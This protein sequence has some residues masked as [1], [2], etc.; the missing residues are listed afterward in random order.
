[1]FT[2][3]LENSLV[4]LAL[5]AVVAPVCY[6]LRSRPAA[7]HLLWLV[8]LVRLVL[9]P[10]PIEPPQALQGFVDRATVGITDLVS[11][12]SA[13]PAHDVLGEGE[14]VPDLIKPTGAGAALDG[15]VARATPTSATSPAPAE[16]AL[17]LAWLDELALVIWIGG[18]LFMLL[19]QLRRCQRLETLVSHAEEAP[20]ELL[21]TVGYMAR[22][23]GVKPPEVRLVKG[24]GSPIIWSLKRP[25]F[26]WPTCRD[27]A[28]SSTCD[29]GIVAH[30]LAHLRRRDHW[31]AWFEMVALCVC[32]WNPVFWAVRR[33][34]RLNAEQACDAWA[35]WA[36]PEHRRA[37]AEALIDIAEQRLKPITRAPVLG[38][39][40]SEPKDFQKRLS[41]IM[42][43]RVSHQASQLIA[44]AAALTAIIL[45]PGITN[46]TPP[47]GGPSGLPGI[48]PELVERVNSVQR[49]TAAAAHY[50]AGRW[51]DAATVYGEIVAARPEDGWARH[52]LGHAL[53]EVGRL[54]EAFA[55]FQAQLALGVERADAESDLATIYASWGKP[56]QAFAHLEAAIDA[57]FK[58]ASWF[59]D[60]PRLASLADD[61][62]FAQVKESALVAKLLH[63]KAM[64][65]VESQDWEKAVATYRKLTEQ[66]PL[67]GRATHM[68]AYSLFGVGGFA[69]AE[70][71]CQ[72]QIAMGFAVPTANYNVACARSRQGDL[73]GAMDAL[74]RSID[75]GFA[76]WGMLADDPDLAPLREQTRMQELLA[77]VDRRGKLWTMGRNAHEAGDWAVAA[78]AWRKLAEVE[79]ERGDA[80]LMLGE[81][82]L[83]LGRHDAAADAL[84]DY[85]LH[86]KKIGDGLYQLA[87]LAQA[88]G[89]SP[90]ALAYLERAANTGFAD[91]ARLQGDPLLSPLQADERFGMALELA[92][93]RARWES[94]NA[95]KKAKEEA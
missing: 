25:V 74:L 39:S 46:A 93:E 8:L 1:M 52:K 65:A 57:G 81:A 61:P 58:D 51:H 68:L 17:D 33:R 70:Q 31:V 26:L 72:T 32:W 47:S 24:L 75:T 20:P 12:A 76:N 94:R 43:P 85:V 2:W 89:D 35:V 30:E 87:R 27:D 66:H 67:D 48:A 22:V 42:K 10:L 21:R 73:E 16:A 18:A 4:T 91:A 28:A 34:L 53:L 79:G 44:A 38:V 29:Q 6:L 14:V 71:V 77:E 13:G 83:E 37:Y 23:I 45:L 59:D 50:E 11:G 88:D 62:R 56:D 90:K 82:L 15:G 80:R 60:E 49:E 64:V 41:M 36:L 19:V 9:P 84:H 86:G 7:C 54:D 5:A 95:Y 92:H 63:D 78:E 3:M 40:E 69:E 55:Q